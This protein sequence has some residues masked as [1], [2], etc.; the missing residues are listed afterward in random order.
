MRG[1]SWQGVRRVGREV[2]RMGLAAGVVV[3]ALACSGEPTA[4]PPVPA[5]VAPAAAAAM[6]AV[7]GQGAE[8][9]AAM[10]GTAAGGQGT[11]ELRA[12]TVAGATV[13]GGQ[14]AEVAAAMV[15]STGVRQG[16]A[17]QGATVPAATVAATAGSAGVSQ[18]S[19]AAVAAMVPAVA[20]TAAAKI[21]PP[22][23]IS[24]NHPARGDVEGGAEPGDGQQTGETAEAKETGGTGDTAE[25]GDAAGAGEAEEGGG[26]TG[27]A[28]GDGGCCES[29]NL[30]G[31][32]TA[33][34]WLDAD[35]MYLADYGGRL[36]LL[37]V[38]T[39]EI[40]TVWEGLTIPQGLTVLEGRLYGTD[41]GNVCDLLESE[42]C[43]PRIRGGKEAVV[44][45]LARSNAWIVSFAIDEDGELG[46][47]R[48]E[49]DGIL[50]VERD[51]SANG[52]TNDGEW[53]YASIGHPYQGQPQP[54]GGFVEQS[55][56]RLAAAGGRPDLMGT[57]ARFKPGDGEVE[58][59]AT[60]LRN[61]YG[62]TIAPDG[63]IYGVDNDTA[64]GLTTEEGQREELNAIVEGGFY[65]YP[66]WGT[67]A[68]PA[69]AGVTEPAAVVAGVAG[70]AVYA[71]GDGVFAAYLSLGE[72][73]EGFVMDYFDYETFTPTRV[74]SNAP[75]YITA[76]LEREGLLYV[77]T[78][79]GLILV[80][81]PVVAE[82]ERQ[83]RRV[84]ELEAKVEERMAAGAPEL[85][86]EWAVYLGEGELILTVSPCG[87]EDLDTWFY[88]VIEPVTVADLP[89]QRRESGNDY[90][91]FRLRDYGA[92]SGEGCI[93]A[94]ALPD[95][96]I[97]GVTVGRRH[98]W[99]GR[100]YLE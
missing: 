16:M 65:G 100:I 60:G 24:S 66:F 29:F 25:D 84:R 63:R 20:G 11:A 69:E 70:T 55:R 98:P 73:G 42:W 74:V 94:V 19:A 18:G 39:G 35:R 93:A 86:L 72:E 91:D 21:P 76:I 61:T 97:K 9:A 46:D 28:A 47:R 26:E 81:D 12:V 15:G 40:R 8:V 34:A 90:F 13:V 89:A 23:N 78:F 14:G 44:A 96:E 53:I 71:N 45:L 64:D 32:L 27:A 95:Y 36:R 92:R 31:Q 75:G 57:I 77:V 50:S 22:S 43:K 49:V 33:A 7:G 85:E 17:A 59:Y 2:V 10:P 58:V 52:L 83:A 79:S 82:G 56:E 87:E 99:M 6:P 37:N 41:M 68:A 38:A 62:I 5:T 54:D 30:G 4:G 51:H 67:G 88:L 48:I 80:V 1:W 3:L